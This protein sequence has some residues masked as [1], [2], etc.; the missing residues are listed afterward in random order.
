MVYGEMDIRKINPW[1]YQAPNQA[2]GQRGK[3][4]SAERAIDRKAQYESK[5]H[6]KARM[7]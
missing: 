2:T 6:R 7:I 3:L 4:R 1:V 5:R